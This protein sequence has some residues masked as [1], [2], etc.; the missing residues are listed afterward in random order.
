MRAL[1]ECRCE[2]NEKS[3]EGKAG[4]RRENYEHSVGVEAYVCTW[5]DASKKK[6]RNDMAKI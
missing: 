1:Q 3:R 2:F 5:N 6:Q 4:N